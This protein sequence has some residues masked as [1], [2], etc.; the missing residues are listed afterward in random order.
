[1]NICVYVFI[2]IIIIFCL[3]VCACVH[4]C[5]LSVHLYSFFVGDCR[6]VFGNIFMLFSL[7]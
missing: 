1:M 6:C 3:C 4:T 2:F 7:L 5:V